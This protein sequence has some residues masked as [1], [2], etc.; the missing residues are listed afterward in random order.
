MVHEVLAAFPCQVTE[1]PTKYLGAPLALSRL[2][3]AQEQ[4]LVD[5]V[6]ARI[7]TW[8]AGLLTQ[9]GRETITQTTLSTIPI[10]IA[11]CCRLSAWAIEEIDK[12]RRAFLWAGT[13]SVMG[14]KCKLAWPVVCSPREYGGLGV[15]D[16]RILV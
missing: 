9:A 2:C 10:H 3:R 11:I 7:P 8:K 1:F 4:A 12:R 5:K 6:S 13:S 16:L 14:G 15:P